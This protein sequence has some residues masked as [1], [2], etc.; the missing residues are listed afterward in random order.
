MRTKLGD[1]MNNFL[2]KALASI[3]AILAVIILAGS[4]ISAG[5]AAAAQGG[6]GM[7]VIGAL[8]GAIGG[9]IA[10]SLVCGTIAFLTLV[11]RHL[12]VLAAAAK[13]GNA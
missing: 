13:S 11:E 9:I 4:T 12:S 2:F 1:L 3:N 10:A 6:P 5:A 8:F 7:F